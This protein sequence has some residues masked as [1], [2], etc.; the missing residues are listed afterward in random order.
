MIRRKFLTILG[1]IPVAAVSSIASVLRPAKGGHETVFCEED[2]VS[3][4]TTVRVESVA[5]GGIPIEWDKVLTIEWGSDG[6]L[7][8]V[9]DKDDPLDVCTP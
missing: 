2:V 3:E 9:V 5:F 8:V 4:A 7:K 1:I 6:V